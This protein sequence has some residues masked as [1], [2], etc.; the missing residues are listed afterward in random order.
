MKE[1]DK[2]S[3]FDT[4]IFLT[5]LDFNLFT[6]LIYTTHSIIEEIEVTKYKEKNRNIL[7]KVQA[8]IES[9]KLIVRAPLEKYLQIVEQKSKIT[10]D[11]KALS[12]A[13]KEIIAI[14]LEIINKC[15]QIIMIYTN[16]YSIENLCSE[17]DIPYSPLGKDG[18]KKKIIWE[19]YCPFCNVP[20]EAEDLN[21]LC[22]RCGS[23]LKRRPKK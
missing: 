15:N 20:Y 6:G 19:V 1:I 11:Y 22:E 9:G 7:N 5:G 10:G 13:D 16:D 4:N 14:A 3:I 2:I 8:A 23:R 17:L 12:D 21:T 18:I